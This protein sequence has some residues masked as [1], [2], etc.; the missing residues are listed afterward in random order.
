MNTFEKSA[1]PCQLKQNSLG[2]SAWFSASFLNAG[3]RSDVGALTEQGRDFGQE[4]D[5]GA[6]LHNSQSDFG[7]RSQSTRE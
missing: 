4:D 6:V 2:C 1:S 5:G 3:P 7:Q